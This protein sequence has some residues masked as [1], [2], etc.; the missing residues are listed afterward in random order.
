MIGLHAYQR[1]NEPVLADYPWHSLL[2]A[3]IRGADSF[4]FE[5]LRVAFPEDVA[6]M[7]ARY[8]APGG[9]IGTETEEASVV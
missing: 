3:L 7:Q 9:R 5:R 2:C 6:E 4:N 8:N 1:S